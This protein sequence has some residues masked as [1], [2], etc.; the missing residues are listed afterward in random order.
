MT[1][2]NDS[3]SELFGVLNGGRQG[4][5]SPILISVYLDELI[6]SLLYCVIGCYFGHYDSGILCYTYDMI[7]V[8]PPCALHSQLTISEEF[9]DIFLL[10]LNS[11]KSQ[12]VC[13]TII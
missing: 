13:F 10:V 8:P 5:L 11:N 6:T 1:Y 9:T 4:G 7:L 12:L 2:W 3:V